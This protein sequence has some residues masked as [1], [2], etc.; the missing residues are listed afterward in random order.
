MV[1]IRFSLLF[2]QKQHTSNTLY[3]GIDFCAVSVSNETE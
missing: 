3:E 2:F 1:T